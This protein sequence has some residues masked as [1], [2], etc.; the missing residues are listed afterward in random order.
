MKEIWEI[1]YYIGK[2][3]YD[4]KEF[5]KLYKYIISNNLD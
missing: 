3:K 2:I 5:E 4:S 1:S